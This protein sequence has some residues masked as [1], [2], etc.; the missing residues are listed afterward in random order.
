MALVK[1]LVKGSALTYAEG[2][3]NLTYL[4]NKVT[5]SVDSFPV[6]D[7][8]NTVTTSNITKFGSMITIDGGLT[9]TG[10]LTAMQY[11]ISS[12][13][14][15]FTE[16]FSS[17][18]TNFGDTLNDTHKFTGSVSITGSLNANLTGSVLGTG[19]YALS[20]L[21]A[22]FATS[23]SYTP[24]LQQVLNSGA[25][26]SNFGAAGSASIQ[27][28]NFS[29]NRTLYLN[30]NSYPTIKMEDNNDAANNLTIDLNTLVLDNVSYN[31][32]DIV[33]RAFIA[34]SLATAS[35]SDNASNA[36]S[37]KYNTYSCGNIDANLGNTSYGLNALKTT[38]SGISN[39]AI[40]ESSLIN[41]TT[42]N[43]NTA[44]GKSALNGNTVGISNTAT[45][46]GALYN[47]TTGSYNTAHGYEALTTNRTGA[48]LTAV[49]YQAAYSNYD[50]VFNT[51][52][53][54][55]AGYYTAAGNN[56]TS[57]GFR[58][59]FFNT[60]GTDN[61]AF[62]LRALYS[63]TTGIQNTGI[64]VDAGRTNSTGNANVFVGFNAG[65]SEVGSNKLYIA[66]SN[67]ATPLIKGDF[68]TGLLQLNTAAGTKI[69]GSLT[70][71]GSSVFSGSATGLVN[72]LSITSNTAS[73]DLTRGNFFTLQLV[74]GADTYINPSNI[75]SG[76]T[77]CVLISTVG[78]GTVSFPTNVFQASDSPYT[79]TTTTG[80]DIITLVSFDTSNLYLTNIKNLV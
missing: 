20:A 64:G 49:G 1:R 68:S 9:V 63:N 10:D 25:G 12:S 24:T 67:T 22:S 61:A 34:T 16:S 40:G 65:Y 78:S 26:A 17:G 46:N 30:N 41:N 73:L 57:T 33:N 66:N 11:I 62:G 18:S 54:Y 45:G 15:H 55:Q 28:T 13:V 37:I 77:I 36:F 7:T 79:P 19:S 35:V 14:T 59:L 51:A 44:I 71:T 27:L 74:G 69:T 4:D 75:Q 31:W 60:S 47:N 23:A 76:Q 21:S 70:V 8:V 5:G 38:T 6:F 58:S 72:S 53:G 52:I 42:G 32:S 56:N 39:V 50:G 3:G 80:K 43:G 48:N 2:D 29:N